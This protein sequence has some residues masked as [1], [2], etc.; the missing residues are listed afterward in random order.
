M[1][2]Q[3]SRGAFDG[4]SNVL[5]KALRAL[6]NGKAEQTRSYIDRALTIPFDDFE[7]HLPAAAAAH[8]MVFAALVDALE[9]IPEGDLAWVDGVNAAVA[10]CGEGERAEL[11]EVLA[12]IAADYHLSRPEERAIQLLC[13]DTPDSVPLLGADRDS[14]DLPSRIESALRVLLVLREEFGA[15]P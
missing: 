7:H 4:A 9:A 12:I 5:R 1:A 13:A 6:Q 11:L 10:R 8:A 2:S 3:V 14:L 15:T